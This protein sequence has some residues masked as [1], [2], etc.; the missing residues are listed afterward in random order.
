[1]TTEIC[2]AVQ[3]CDMPECLASAEFDLSLASSWAGAIYRQELT[4][5]DVFVHNEPLAKPEPEAEPESGSSPVEPLL[6]CLHISLH[7]TE[8]PFICGNP[9]QPQAVPVAQ[10]SWL[11]LLCSATA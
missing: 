8:M 9:C 10:G 5:G 2:D 4:V 1:M 6:W 3:I 7:T 11:H